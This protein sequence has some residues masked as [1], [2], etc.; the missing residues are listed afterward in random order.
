[1][2]TA[3]PKPSLSRSVQPGARHR[4][5]PEATTALARIRELSAENAAL[6]L[7]VVELE[8]SKRG[9]KPL[10]AMSAKERYD[11]LSTITGK[12]ATETAALQRAFYLKHIKP[13]RGLG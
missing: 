9:G 13:L 2:K 12:D 7:R 4:A 8:F 1:M 3:L 10:R 5:A 6:K 11:K